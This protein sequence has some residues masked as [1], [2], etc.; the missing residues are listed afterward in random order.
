MNRR[1]FVGG[2]ALL[3]ASHIPWSRRRALAQ[4]PAVNLIFRGGLVFDGTGAPPREADVAVAGDRI[5]SVGPGQPAPSAEEVDVRGLAIAPGF[6]DIHSHTDMELFIDPRAE[7]K[8][9][10]GV[11][12]EVAGQDGGSLGPWSAE[13]ADRVR[14]DYRDRHGVDISFHDLA[15]FFQTLDRQP[16]AV[17]L[18]SMVGQGTVRQYVMGGANRP[19]TEPELGQM[20]GLIDEALRAGACGISTGLEYLPGTFSSLEE[21]ARVAQPLRPLGLPYATHMRNED[22]QLFA[23]VE[24]ALNVGREAGVPVHISHLKAQGKRNWWKAESILGSLMAA[25]GDGVDVTYD[26]YPYV[27]YSTGLSSLFPVYAREG[28]ATAFLARLDDAGEAPAIERAVRDKVTKL[29][30]WDAV[31][32]TATVSPELS[33][34]QGRRLGELAAE[35]ALEP[36]QLLLQIVRGDRNRTGMVGFGMSEDN[37]A[38]FLRHPLGMVCSDGTALATDGPLSGGSPHPRSYGTFPR[39]L[40]YYARDQ[41]VMPLEIAIHKMTGQPARRLRL[42]G[43]GVIEPGAFAD[44]V[45][46]DA[47]RVADRATFE[48]PHQYPAGIPHVLVNGSFVVRDGEHTGAKPGRVLRGV[49]WTG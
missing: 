10:Q 17:N 22:D 23:A 31:Q 27:A 37:T 2:V 48:Q 6:I 33:W 3:T 8:V 35:R 12:S 41:K 39:V 1:S 16:A 30:S 25:R 7:S 19:A 28:G 49:G 45:L 43:R 21:L 24:E 14:Q 4:L 11:T 34:A 26:R 42:A 13:Q 20:V 46:F 15:G 47:D 9:R 36:Y 5:A 40:G 18:A 29:G 32:I 38:L 44:L